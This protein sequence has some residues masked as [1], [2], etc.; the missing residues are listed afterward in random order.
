MY[1]NFLNYT[2]GAK[3]DD[4]YISL[5]PKCQRPGLPGRNPNRPIMIH[6]ATRCKD[7]TLDIG[8]MCDLIAAIK[9]KDE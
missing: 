9:A 7:K 3:F 1:L 8:F 6:I 2:V 5:C 4:R